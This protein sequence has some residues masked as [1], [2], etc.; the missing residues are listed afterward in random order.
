MSAA[1]VARERASPSS[2]LSP[3]VRGLL[4]AQRH[5][6][7]ATH[8]DG[9]ARHGRGLE[10]ARAL[11]ERYGGDPDSHNGQHRIRIVFEPREVALHGRLAEDA[12]LPGR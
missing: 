6:V 2:P 11:A 7:I 5:A 4:A 1:R 8:D 9:R 10:E 12:A 3:G